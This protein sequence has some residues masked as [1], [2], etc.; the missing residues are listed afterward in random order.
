MHRLVTVRLDL[1]AIKTNMILDITRYPQNLL[2][3]L[4]NA[5]DS[6]SGVDILIGM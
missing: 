4:L 2:A 3:L 1:S 6:I 5:P